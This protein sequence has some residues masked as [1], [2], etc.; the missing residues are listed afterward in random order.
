MR[1]VRGRK[2]NR[3]GAVV[4][5]RANH[6]RFLIQRKDRGRRIG[7]GEGVPK[8][9]KEHE[10]TDVKERS[11]REQIEVGG[12]ELVQEV[13][14]LIKEGNVRELKILAEDGEVKLEIP[15][16]IGVI[17]GGVVTLAAPWLALLGVIA[18]LVTKVRIEVE[19]VQDT[20][21]LP[22]PEKTEA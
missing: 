3:V 22:E 13:K 17:A 15:L 19:R 8:A 12:G 7:Q 6:L 20:P 2:R 10:M 9:R 21:V 18:A 11:L 1:T 5:G 14:R 16:T 4:R